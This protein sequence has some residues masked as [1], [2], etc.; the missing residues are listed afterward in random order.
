MEF[1]VLGW[2]PDGPRL[3]LDHRRFAYAGKFVI[4]RTGKAVAR[5]D[6][7]VLGASAFDP[8]RTDGTVLRIRYVTVRRDRQGE[9]IGARLLAFTADRAHDRGFDRI[10][11]AVNNPIAYQ[12]AYR[13]G[14]GFTGE[15]TGLAEL[16]LAHPGD[17]SEPSYRR[18]LARFLER[19]DLAASTRRFVRS[20]MTASLPEP[21]LPPEPT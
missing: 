18:G 13:A 19:E 10:R 12:A 9:G 2:P 14:F 7:D 20:R 1:E 6:G 3:Q 5:S 15:G 4:T 8:D 16:V 21:V 17:R 11:I